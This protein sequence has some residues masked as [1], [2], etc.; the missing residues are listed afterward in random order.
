M[1]KSVAKI[2]RQWQAESESDQVCQFQFDREGILHIY[3]SQPDCFIG[4]HG[5]LV[6]KY[7]DILKTKIPELQCVKF[8]ET[9]VKGK[10]GRK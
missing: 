1:G 6:S 9:V 4:P 8:E 3:T 7:I 5:V 2:L 10:Y